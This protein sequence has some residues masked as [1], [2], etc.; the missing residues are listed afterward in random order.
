MN[1][2]GLV[3]QY[4]GSVN[5]LIQITI[6][7]STGSTVRADFVPV[8]SYAAPITVLAQVQPLSTR[9]LQQLEGINL[10]GEMRSVYLNGIVNGVVRVLLKGGD[11]ITLPDGTIWLVTMVPEAWNLTAGWTKAVITLQNG[12]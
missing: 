12:S 7:V 2:H 11:L 10:G 3:S 6:Q 1:L 5:P 4:V 8:P 9:D